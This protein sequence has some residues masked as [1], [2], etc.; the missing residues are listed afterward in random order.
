MWSTLRHSMRKVETPK[1]A[2]WAV[3]VNNWIDGK[4]VVAY[5][6]S[7]P[8]LHRI[9]SILKHLPGTVQSSDW[10]YLDAQKQ[11]FSRVFTYDPEDERNPSARAYIDSLALDYVYKNLN[12]CNYTD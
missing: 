10:A 1:L 8:E 3:R 2:Q 4:E 11:I 7:R 9:E 6:S 5:G 12:T